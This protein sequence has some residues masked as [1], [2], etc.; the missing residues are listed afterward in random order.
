MYQIVLRF[1]RKIKEFW[2]SVNSYQLVVLVNLT[3]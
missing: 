3:S 1:E 2:K